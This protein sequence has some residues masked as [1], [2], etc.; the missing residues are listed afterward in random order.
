MSDPTRRE[1]I[2]R[3]LIDEYRGDGHDIVDHEGQIYARLVEWTRRG[4]VVLAEINLDTLASQID[5]RLP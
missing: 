4:A 5:R 1:N 3:I 2:L